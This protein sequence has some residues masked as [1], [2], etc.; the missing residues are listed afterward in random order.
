[1]VAPLL[2]MGGIGAISTFIGAYQAYQAKQV[3]DYT[4][5]YSK[6][7]AQDQE[8]FWS[9]YERRTGVKVKYPY[10]TGSIQDY[11]RYYSNRFKSNTAYYNVGRSALGYTGGL[12]GFYARNRNYGFAGGYAG[13]YA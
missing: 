8:R 2:I 12:A 11:S 5:N 1:M 7:Y 6:L 4:A 10:R 13:M 9:D 3:S